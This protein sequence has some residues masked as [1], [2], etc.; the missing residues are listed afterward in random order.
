MIVVFRCRCRRRCR[1]RRGL[2]SSF[3]QPCVRCELANRQ[4]ASDNERSLLGP[5]MTPSR[6]RKQ[7]VTPPTRNSIECLSTMTD[8]PG[9]G[10]R[11][12]ESVWMAR[13]H[14]WCPR[15]QSTTI[16][17]E[18]RVRRWPHLTARDIQREREGGRE[19]GL[20]CGLPRP[21]SRAN[22][23]ELARYC[24]QPR[25]TRLPLN[26]TCLKMM[27]VLGPRLRASCSILSFL[28]V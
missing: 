17:A 22:R 9:E 14:G 26:M 28:R 27:V 6:D 5:Q 16:E 21:T 8:R 25:G 18:R 1:R 4:E 10:R 3:R 23:C 19:G 12:G 15:R 24:V 13:A 2:C 7:R 11:V 20:Q